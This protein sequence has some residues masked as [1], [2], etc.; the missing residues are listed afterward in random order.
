MR[1]LGRFEVYSGT[2]FLW[3][4]NASMSYATSR[5]MIET[6]ERASCSL[7]PLGQTKMRVAF[8][9]LTD[10]LLTSNRIPWH[11]LNPAQFSLKEH[12]PS[13]HDAV[14][15]SRLAVAEKVFFAQTQLRIEMYDD[16][17]DAKMTAYAHLGLACLNRLREDCDVA[18]RHMLTVFELT[19]RLARQILMPKVYEIL[20][21][22][23]L[24]QAAFDGHSENEPEWAIDKGC[25]E[26]AKELRRSLDCNLPGG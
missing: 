2:G 5:E 9:A 16:I 19:P 15:Q 25:T 18:R 23:R 12:L 21:K 17:P 24:K 4:V 14:R 13:S 7:D 11:V 10:H 8:D 26:I 6:L 1:S 3:L 20:F 22:P